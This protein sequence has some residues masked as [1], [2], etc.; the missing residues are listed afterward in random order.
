MLNEVHPGFYTEFVPDRLRV[1][2]LASKQLLCNC[3]S[4]LYPTTYAKCLVL[5]FGPL[6]P[7]TCTTT[8]WNFACYSEEMIL[9]W[10][11]IT[12]KSFFPLLFFQVEVTSWPINSV[13]RLRDPTCSRRLVARVRSMQPSDRIKGSD[14]IFLLKLLILIKIVKLFW[15]WGQQEREMNIQMLTSCLNGL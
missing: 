15:V 13:K 7:A 2:F 9:C 8:T 11:C 6:F 14:F 5:C 3:L 10:P 1:F 12:P 4:K